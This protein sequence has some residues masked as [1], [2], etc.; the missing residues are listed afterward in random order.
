MGFIFPACRK[1]DESGHQ[2]SCST[3]LA[4]VSSQRAGAAAG[5]LVLE[6][7]PEMALV[8][9]CHSFEARSG[10]HVLR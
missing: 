8:E 3:E 5:E 6:V 2:C 1:A 10:P 4:V 7:F 9:I